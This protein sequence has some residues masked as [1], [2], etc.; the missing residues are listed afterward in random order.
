MTAFSSASVRFEQRRRDV[1]DAARRTITENG[2]EATTLRD[3]AREGGFTTGVVTHYF[4][5]KRAVIVGAFAAASHD[6]LSAARAAIND[7]GSVELQ[8]EALVGVALPDD[9]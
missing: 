6:W 7:A 8:L 5:D 1:C 3:I 9:A 4:P 2:L